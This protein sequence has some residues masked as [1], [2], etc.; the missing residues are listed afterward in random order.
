MHQLTELLFVDEFLWVS[1]LQYL[2][3]EWENAVFLW[4]MLQAGQPSLHYYC[5]VLLQSCIVL[6]PVGHSSNH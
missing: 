2:K 3:N 5:A 4:C 6:P 1:H